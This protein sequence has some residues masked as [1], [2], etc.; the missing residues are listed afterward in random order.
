MEKQFEADISQ[1]ISNTNIPG[2]EF[3]MKSIENDFVNYPFKI[4]I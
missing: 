2:F 3:S 4:L 1:L